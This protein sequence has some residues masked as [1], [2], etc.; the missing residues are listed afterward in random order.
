MAERIEL[1]TKAQIA[2]LTDPAAIKALI[3]DIEG[4]VTTI[5]TRLEYSGINDDDWRARA[6]GALIRHRTALRQLNR[7]AHDL[8]FIALRQPSRPHG[9]K[10]K[11][12]SKPANARPDSENDPLTN[13]SLDQ[14]HVIDLGNFTEVAE[15]DAKLADLDRRIAAVSRDRDDEIAT[16]SQKRDEGF[17]AATKSTL[18]AMRNNR[19]VLQT[20]RNR[21]VRGTVGETCADKMQRQERRERR[22]VDAA[23]DLLPTATFQAIWDRVERQEVEIAGAK[24]TA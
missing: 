21:L 5:E 18:A 8:R 15:A 9:R 4:V 11:L 2:A 23:R 10:T 20:H 6:Q 16:P 1:P 19:S 24:V 13:E 17:L 22:F 12:T 3:E 7:R 14:D